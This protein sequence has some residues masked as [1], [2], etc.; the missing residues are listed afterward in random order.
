MVMFALPIMAVNLLQLVFNAADMIVVGRFEGARAL[1]AVGATGS[2]F[3]LIVNLFMGLSVGTAVIVAQDYGARR[4]EGIR[5]SVHTSIAVSLIGGGVATAIG[6]SFCAPLLRWMGTPED[7]IGLS[8][9]YMRIV[10]AGMPASMVFNFGAAIL[11]AVGDSRR[12]MYFLVV[13]GA[14]NVVFNLFFVAVLRLGVAGV[15]WATVI[16]QYLA[17]I[18]IM[19]SLSR[20]EGALRFQWQRLKIHRQKLVQLLRIG[21]PAGLQSV[22]FSISNVLIQSAVNSFGTTMVAA[23]AASSNVENLVA[24]PMNAYYQAAITFTGQSMGAEDYDRIDRIAK[25]CTALVFVTW[26]IL[27]GITLSFGRTLLAFYT[28]DPAV[29]ELGMRRMKVLMSLY[30]TCGIMNVFPGL[31]RAMGYS[32]LPMLS[33]LVGACL[34]RIVWLATVFRLYPTQLVLFAVYPVTW[35]IA[36]LGQVASFFYARSRIRKRAVLSQGQAEAAI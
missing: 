1:A 15:G 27:G 29:I 20:Q 13:S 30:F 6:L 22:L 18:L 10:F 2:L 12:P 7:I 5:Q 26:L 32:V 28:T 9:L 35:T 14:V 16:S 34:L 23:S 11:R 24:T 33:T 17:L 19:I 21:V 25:N 8:T 31:T 4:V 36:G 3:N